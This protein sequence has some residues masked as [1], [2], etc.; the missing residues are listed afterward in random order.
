MVELVACLIL[1]WR[2]ENDWKNVSHG[3]MGIEIIEL[4]IEALV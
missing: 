4:N 2:N 3:L 1:G